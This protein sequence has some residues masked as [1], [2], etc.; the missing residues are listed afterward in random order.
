MN[1]EGVRAGGVSEV[2]V[3]VPESGHIGEGIWEDSLREEKMPDK[4][5]IPSVPVRDIRREN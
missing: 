3:T 4:I 2:G 1:L 5:A